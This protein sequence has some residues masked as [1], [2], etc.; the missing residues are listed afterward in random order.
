MSTNAGIGKKLDDK[1]DDGKWEF[2]YHHWDGNPRSLGK[3]LYD[4]YNGY[5]QKDLGKM[6]KVLL[7]EHP[8]GWSTINEKDF[9]LAPGYT[10]FRHTGGVGNQFD[11]NEYY[12]RLEEYEQSGDGRRPQCYC[13]GD[14][15]EEAQLIEYPGSS[16]GTLEYLY[17]FDEGTLHLE[18]YSVEGEGTPRM[19]ANVDLNGEEPD[20][21]KIENQG[22]DS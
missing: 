1:L 19:L 22:D 20:W 5:F 16:L 4:L 21:K 7:D 10:P 3:T 8:A 6:L 13:H 14:R 2:R 15:N 17:V 18:V 9:S 12:K 11:M